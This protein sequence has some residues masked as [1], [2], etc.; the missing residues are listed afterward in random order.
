M[1]GNLFFRIIQMGFGVFCP[2]QTCSLQGF[3]REFAGFFNQESDQVSCVIVMVGYVVFLKLLK[4]KNIWK[5]SR[6]M[7][8]FAKKVFTGL[9]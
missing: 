6:E 5:S 1:A 3:G 4:N 2:M 8:F 7:H 9:I